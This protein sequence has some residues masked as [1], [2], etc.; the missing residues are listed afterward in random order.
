[1]V[2]DWHKAGDYAAIEDYIRD[3]T[4]KFLKYYQH[5]VTNMPQFWEEYARA[6]GIIE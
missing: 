2:A 1:M 5:L 4:E 3:E 6:N